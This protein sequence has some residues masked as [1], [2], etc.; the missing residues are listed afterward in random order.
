[1]NS[2]KAEVFLQL[3]EL[4]TSVRFVER[5]FLRTLVEPWGTLGT[6]LTNWTNRR[7]GKSMGHLQ[8]I[9]LYCQEGNPREQ[10]LKNKGEYTEH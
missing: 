3:G 2:E 8:F 4:G 6:P 9:S 10:P 1:M 7:V 5:H